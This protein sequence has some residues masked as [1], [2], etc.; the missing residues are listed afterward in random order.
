MPELNEILNRYGFIALVGYML[1]R[2]LI[3]WTLKK[4]FPTMWESRQRATIRAEKIEDEERQHRQEMEKRQIKA[5]ETIAES[6]AQNTEILAELKT[7]VAV[8]LQRLDT[9]ETNV[10]NLDDDVGEMSKN[11]DVILDRTKRK[12]KAEG[13][14]P[15]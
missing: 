9:L 4:Y 2:D 7:L 12:N 13:D 15:A 6:D 11:V 10:K 5:I 1:I 8:V 3:P 14:D